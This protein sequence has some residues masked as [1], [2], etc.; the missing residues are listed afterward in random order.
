MKW[1]KV[2]YRDYTVTYHKIIEAESYDDA[3]QKAIN[4]NPM[5]RIDCIEIIREDDPIVTP[6]GIRP[7][8]TNV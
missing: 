8:G 2:T 7:G 6:G 3:E 4:A 5:A 1:Y